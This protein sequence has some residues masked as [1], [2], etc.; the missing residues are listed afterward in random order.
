MRIRSTPADSLRVGC[1]RCSP[2]RSRARHPD[3][4][5]RELH[6]RR[7]D[8]PA[9]LAMRQLTWFGAG[10]LVML[11]D[12]QLRLPPARAPRVPHLPG[13]C[14]SWCS[15]SRW[16][17]RWAAAR[18]A[19]STSGRC[20]CSRR[21]SSKLALVLVLAR[22]F[23]LTPPAKLGLREAAIPLVADVAIPAAA[24]LAQPDLGSAA[25]VVLVSVTM[26]V[27]RRACSIRWLALLAL[28]GRAAR[29]AA[30][31]APQGVPAAAHPHLPRSRRRIRSAPAIT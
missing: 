30:L 11:G 7:T 15:R 22:Y 19:G 14:C 23:S 9:P 21:R 10:V 2:S 16:S 29:A 8:S 5:Q 18:G 13:R 25:L 20:R 17:G 12:A 1:S 28:A 6:A 26:L 4:L 27:L 24:I 31:V 3:D